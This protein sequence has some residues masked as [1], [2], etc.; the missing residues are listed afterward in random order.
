M[1]LHTTVTNETIKIAIIEDE[2]IWRH[3][4]TMA[5]TTL[6]YE[7]A[8]VAATFED[9]IVLLADTQY[10]LV[11][12]DVHLH[13]RDS[14]VELGRIINKLHK[15]PFIFITATSDTEVMKHA[16]E[17]QPAA[18][19][20]KPINTTS[21][22]VAIQNAI[23]HYSST[24]KHPALQDVEQQTSFFFVKSGDRYKKLEWQDIVYLQSDKNYTYLLN[25]AD[26]TRYSIRSTLSKTLKNILPP[27]MQK[28]IVQIN[29]AEAIHIAH[30]KEVT[31]DEVRTK[32]GTFTVTEGYLDSLKSVIQIIS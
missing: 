6:G 17:T 12:L 29:R 1:Q 22:M 26:N 20:T 27:H 21:L 7:V 3:G 14:G 5:L 9:G 30:I 25:A 18:Y 23:H 24:T 19:L 15:K 2:E 13:N 31:R 16:A 32:F 11:L 10:D 8:G 4:L 28:N